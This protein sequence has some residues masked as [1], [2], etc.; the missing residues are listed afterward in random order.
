MLCYFALLRRRTPH[1]VPIYLFG[2]NDVVLQDVKE[3]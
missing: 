1:G 2:V 3:L